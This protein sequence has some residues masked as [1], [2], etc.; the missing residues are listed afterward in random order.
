MYHRTDICK[1]QLLS[2][3]DVVRG[4][5]RDIGIDAPESANAPAVSTSGEVDDERD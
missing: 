2:V 5:A 4:L 3:Y 1:N